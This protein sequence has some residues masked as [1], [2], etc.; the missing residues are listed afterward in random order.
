MPRVPSFRQRRA[1]VGAGRIPQASISN[2]GATEAAVGRLGGQIAEFSTR[3]LDARTKAEETA[4]LNSAAEKSEAEFRE[5][6]ARRQAEV[7]SE[8][9]ESFAREEAERLRT[10]DLQGAPTNRSRQTYEASVAPRFQ[11]LISS[12]ATKER[13][14]RA[15][16]LARESDLA[17]NAAADSVAIEART[18]PGNVLLLLDD[19]IKSREDAIDADSEARL[20]PA[21]RV[22]DAK[23]QSK[24]RITNRYLEAMM[25]SNPV[26]AAQELQSGKGFFRDALGGEAERLDWLDKMQRRA[27]ANSAESTKL[28]R[29]RANLIIKDA[30]QNGSSKDL[31]LRFMQATAGLRPDDQ[32]ILRTN[33]A[34][35]SVAKEYEQRLLED[36]QN[37]PSVEQL[38]DRRIKELGVSTRGAEGQ[39]IKSLAER[40]VMAMQ[41]EIL[42]E[43]NTD[44]AKT[45]AR[46]P[47]M[48]AKMQASVSNPL[49]Q[50]QV[51]E[52]MDAKYARIGIPKHKRQVISEPMA[53]VWADNLQNASDRGA[54]A[55]ITQMEQVFGGDT[56]R[57]MS[58]L[59]LKGK[60]N[61]TMYAIS[62]AQD[63]DR[64]GLISAVRNL[65]SN[66]EAVLTKRLTES[67]IRKKISDRLED[68]DRIMLKGDARSGTRGVMSG[69]RELIFAQTLEQ[70][71]GEFVTSS[72][73]INGTIDRAFD[74]VF[75]KNWH[76]EGSDFIM[77]REA[78]IRD[79]SGAPKRFATKID[80]TV[81]LVNSLD[82]VKSLRDQGFNVQLAG[83]ANEQRDRLAATNEMID[84]LI[85][86]P[87]P[88]NPYI[89]TGYVSGTRGSA[90][91]P[92][93]DQDGNKLQIDTTTGR[94]TTV[95]IEEFRM[96]GQPGDLNRQLLPP[97]RQEIRQ[98]ASIFTEQFENELT[99]EQY[100]Q[101]GADLVSPTLGEVWSAG[102]RLYDRDTL[103]GTARQV[104]ALTELKER[105]GFELISPEDLNDEYNQDIRDLG[106]Q[107]FRQRMNR[108]AAQYVIDAAREKQ[109]LQSIV[110]GGQDRDWYGV[111]RFGAGLAAF[112]SDPREIGIAAG[113]GIATAATAGMFGVTSAAGILGLSAVENFSSEL[114]ARGLVRS[115][116]LEEFGEDFTAQD[117][118]SE[119]AFGATIGMGFTGLGLAIRGV[120]PIVVKQYAKGMDSLNQNKTFTKMRSAFGQ[121][122]DGKKVDIQPLNEAEAVGKTDIG[123][124]E[125]PF[126]EF[127]VAQPADR[128]FFVPVIGRQ[129][130]LK[131]VTAER[132]GQF[133]DEPLGDVV[134][135]SDNKTRANNVSLDDYNQAP[136]GVIEATL[137]PEARL[138]D[139]DQPLEFVPESFGQIATNR[140]AREVLEDIRA[141]AIRDNKPDDFFD[142]V[143]AEFKAAGFSGYKKT[144]RG[145]GGTDHN[146]VKVFDRDAIVEKSYSASRSELKPKLSSQVQKDITDALEADERQASFDGPSNERATIGSERIAQE[147]DFVSDQPTQV[148][149][150]SKEIQAATR[151]LLNSDEFK[152][153]PKDVQDAVSA[154][155]AQADDVLKQAD[156]EE[157]I[158]QNFIGCTLRNG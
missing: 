80:E 1:S 114:V 40:Q 96:S 86:K 42:R 94:F 105:E 9:L 68:V 131:G 3:L 115:E 57:V 47:E 142:Q 158:L 144:L 140:P 79:R 30:E 6:I 128:S 31:D 157:S 123:Q 124:E 138:I 38:T 145:D 107:P 39:S 74:D 56:S 71:R 82:S 19:K 59:K 73:S 148:S 129:Q 127:D 106:I 35:A 23:M 151:E 11:S 63:V 26:R 51:A 113:A 4:Y 119:A 25:D 147:N 125:L 32:Q 89:L 36:P 77:P 134:T 149:A 112:L 44:S 18:N 60:I 95:D 120:K 135:M 29:H 103:G 2:A 99:A 132:F 20:I 130:R 53:Q 81:R 48:S 13:V 98:M 37:P 83:S 126:S 139:L 24:Q 5:N 52:E 110:D 76:I 28:Q 154:R 108:L 143:N 116:R 102:L 69:Y 121:S 43:V 21:E 75:K 65:K 117:I 17:D 109:D 104:D 10:R 27:G 33:Y 156:A 91:T 122:A 15:E 155:V 88:A 66:K 22:S 84:S 136:G 90:I 72:S 101:F 92:M 150:Q 61:D 67:N 12:A 152:E 58:E 85:W 14:A 34:L 64:P 50:G 111:T 146:V 118:L 46:D 62:F 153:L 87:D 16:S 100:S 45:V 133:D 141:R 70:A 54:A 137:S 41:A 78:V 8:G 7:G 55:T 49:L 93:F 97:E